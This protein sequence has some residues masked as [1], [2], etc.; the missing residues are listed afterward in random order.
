MNID[1]LIFR[2]SGIMVL[3]TLLLAQLHNPGWFWVTTFIGANLL[4]SSF[5]GFCPLV[6]VLKPLGI[7]PGKAFE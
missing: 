6:K 3:L 5:T 2:F 7:R 1:R 4:Q